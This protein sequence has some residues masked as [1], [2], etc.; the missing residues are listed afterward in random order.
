[1]KE[2]AGKVEA[3]ACCSQVDLLWWRCGESGGV[4]IVTVRKS[5]WEAVALTQENSGSGDGGEK[6]D[7]RAI[8]LN[9][10]IE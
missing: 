9:L 4:A 5:S 1:M 3:G 7:W 2:L 10:M 8:W 6:T